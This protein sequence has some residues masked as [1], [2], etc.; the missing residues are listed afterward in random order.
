MKTVD[1]VIATPSMLGPHQPSAYPNI[2][3]V[4]VAGEACPQ[5]DVSICL[6]SRYIFEYYF[7]LGLADEWAKTV[8]FYN[9]CGP[10]EVST[11]YAEESCP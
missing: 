6:L 3:V 8:R 2:K 9:C 1:V 10:T 7:Y 5:G 11:H 4:A